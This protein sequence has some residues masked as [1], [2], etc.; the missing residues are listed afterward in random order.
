[1][2]RQVTHSRSHSPRWLSWN[3][4]PIW[5]QSPSS[6]PMSSGVNTH[7]S[8]KPSPQAWEQSSSWHEKVWLCPGVGLAA[9]VGHQMPRVAWSSAQSSSGT[10]SKPGSAEAREKGLAGGGGGGASE[11]AQVMPPRITPWRLEEV[12]RYLAPLSHFWV[13]G[14]AGPCYPLPLFSGK[15]RCQ[16][17]TA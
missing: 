15:P 14:G 9:R 10:F 17:V 6:L 7:L 11:P 12:A 13:R 5:F 4:S 1:M 3:P 16:R 8:V 2:Q